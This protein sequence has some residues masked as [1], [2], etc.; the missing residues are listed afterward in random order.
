MSQL[1]PLAAARAA[2]AKYRQ[3]GGDPLA[4]ARAEAAKHSQPIST[5]VGNVQHVAGGTSSA[6]L[7][8]WTKKQVDNAPLRPFG[9]AVARGAMPILNA[10]D[11]P[12]RANV[13]LMSSPRQAAALLAEPLA[14]PLI[15]SYNAI[16]TLRGKNTPE[17]T[18]ASQARMLKQMHL[19][20]NFWTQ[21]GVSTALDPLTYA[22]GGTKLLHGLAEAHTLPFFTNKIA[23][24]LERTA[25]GRV[26]N[27]VAEKAHD[28]LGVESAEKRQLAQEYGKEWVVKYGQLTG[29]RSAK[30]SAEHQIEGVIANK[31]L[32]ATK[33]LTNQNFIGVVKA[34]NDGTIKMLPESLQANARKLQ[35]IT[36]AQKYLE[37]DPQLKAHLDETYTLPDWAKPLEGTPAK[38]RGIA[39]VRQN[40]VPVLGADIAG[41]APKFTGTRRISTLLQQDPSLL[42]RGNIPSSAFEDPNAA[43]EFFRQSYLHRGKLT[44][45]NLATGGILPRAAATFPK[46]KPD[47]LFS[48]MIE[49][50]EPKAPQYFADLAKKAQDIEKGNIFITPL[51]HMWNIGVLQMLRSPSSIPKTLWEFGKTLRMSDVDRMRYFAPEIYHGA[52]Q[53][54]SYGDRQSAFA[55]ALGKIAGVIENRGKQVGTPLEAKILASPFRIGSGWYG[56]VG[57][58]LWKFDDAAKAV[59]FRQEKAAF[60]RQGLSEA[61]AAARAAH[62]VN[63]SLVDYNTRSQLAEAMSFV[64][65]FATWRTKSP[66]ATVRSII[67]NPGPFNFAGRLSPA[68]V[69]GQTNEPGKKATASSL[70]PAELNKL[71]TDPMSWLVAGV[72]PMVRGA[73]NPVINRLAQYSSLAP[74][75]LATYGQPTGKY[76]EQ[77]TPFLGQYLQLTGQGMFPQSP[78]KQLL[79]TTGA[80]PFYT[81]SKQTGQ[82]KGKLKNFARLYQQ[83]H[84]D[85]T[86][87]Q[88]RAA[89]SVFSRNMSEAGR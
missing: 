67:R 31:F 11:V 15:S 72:N 79:R 6:P 68:A 14:Y 37:A 28:L 9:E 49:L 5:A 26:V 88:I 73:A 38:P 71:L 52:V 33:G 85:A 69:G 76:L 54:G 27:E 83:T 61:S 32:D 65:P 56:L 42:Q 48:K 84:P 16:Q 10:L 55:N 30:Q 40:Y 29:L 17:Q 82:L 87:A 63:A 8:Q 51:G 43:S 39:N 66:M 19:P 50:G 24:L 86:D 59:A 70:P 1:D 7:G 13:S 81:T 36:D 53:V 41:K 75:N 89:F 20:S 4:A 57:N 78:G 18:Q 60:L 74:P 80:S 44:A 34:I 3:G 47:E 25:A 22:G 35:E 58:A 12:H 62:E 2:A 77:N 45:Q 21:L 23:P 64:Y 46:V